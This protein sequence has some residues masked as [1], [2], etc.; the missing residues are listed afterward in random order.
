MMA[1]VEHTTQS[2]WLASTRLHDCTGDELTMRVVQDAL[3]ALRLN[4][5]SATVA[6]LADRELQRMM[7]SAGGQWGDG[8]C[9]ESM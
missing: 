1:S 9:L 7:A 8:Y 3:E 4:E 5:W 2:W 6:Q